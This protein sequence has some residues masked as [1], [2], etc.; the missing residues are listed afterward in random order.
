MTNGW[1][2][3]KDGDVMKA[4]RSSGKVAVTSSK[5]NQEKWLEDNLWY[6]LDSTAFESLAETV[7]S[8]LLRQ[9][10]I[11]SQLGYQVV[12]YDITQVERKG[13]QKLG[14]VSPNFLK[15]GQSI[16]TADHLLRRTI[17]LDYQSV[18]FHKTTTLAQI[19]TAFVDAMVDATGLQD[20]GKYLTLLFECDALICNVDR[21][22]NNIAVL[23]SPQGYEYCPIFDNGASFLLNPLD[24][25]LDVDTKSLA[26]SVRAKPFNYTFG[27]TVRTA[28]SLYGKQLEWHMTAKDVADVVAS[29][30]QHY[31]QMYHPYLLDRILDVV[32]LG[33]KYHV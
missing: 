10:N 15:P 27:A 24:Y 25:P 14:C 2:S 9:S 6:K 22:L 28:R 3:K 16:I 33:R 20:F 7:A 1:T 30:L 18:L 21:H 26:K 12:S 8:N 31:P 17:G 23:I 13:Q 11:T 4:L 19:M 29:N 5:G 32:A